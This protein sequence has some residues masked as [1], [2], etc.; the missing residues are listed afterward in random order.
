MDKLTERRSLLIRLLREYERL[1]NLQPAPGVE[2]F[3]ILD[4]QRDHYLL[5]SVGWADG[6]RVR[7]AVLYVRLRN[8]KFWIEEDWTENGIA[9]DLLRD[10]VPKDDI[11]LAFQAPERRPL[12]EF[13]VA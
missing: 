6:R 11:V 5:M 7:R 3:V 13:A 9:T 12:T 8:G 1:Y 2:T 10:A 4:E